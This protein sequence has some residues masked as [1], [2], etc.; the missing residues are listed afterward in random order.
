MLKACLYSREARP[1][2]QHRF[3]MRRHTANRDQAIILV[4]VDTGLRASELC[5]LHIGD[6]D[7][8]TGR[9]EVKHGKEGGS[10][11]GKGRTV[12]L[13]KVARWAVWRYLAEREM[14]VL[15]LV[16]QG[17][18]NQQIAN[19][20]VISLATVKAHISNTLAKLQVSSRAE[21]IAYA[22]KHKNV[23]L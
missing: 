20:M 10:K 2:D 21:A 15:R 22:L 4:L 16:V 9:V 12:Y 19:A 17:Q 11:G 14:E 8:K 18:S 1:H 3:V 7:R 6:V 13:G 5:S 23:S